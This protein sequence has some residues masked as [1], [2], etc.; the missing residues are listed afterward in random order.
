MHNPN[1]YTS[2]SL[3]CSELS[4]QPCLLPA[5]SCARYWHNTALQAPPEPCGTEYLS[6]VA[7]AS[8]RV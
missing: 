5:W 8:L 1:G 6:P 2:S 4:Q 7:A 3:P